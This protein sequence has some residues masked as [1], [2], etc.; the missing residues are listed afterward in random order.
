MSYSIIERHEGA[1]SVVSELGRGTVFTIDLLAYDAECVEANEKSSLAEQSS[2]SVLVVDDEEFVRETLAEMLEAMGHRVLIA[3]S[4]QQAIERLGEENFD[5]V[6]TDLAMP[7]MD[8]WE[9]AREI[10]KRWPEMNIVLVTGYGPGTTPPDGEA[11]LVNAVIGKP[12]DFA[13]VSNTI[14]QVCNE[15]PLEHVN[16]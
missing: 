1:I 5:L 3:E 2:L 15:R 16:V 8:G 11:Q 14:A 7:E 10:R 13:Q 6:F 9:T 4:G 12:F